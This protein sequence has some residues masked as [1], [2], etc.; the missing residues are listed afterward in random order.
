MFGS[1]SRTTTFKSIIYEVVLSRAILY[2]CSIKPLLL[3]KKSHF[4]T[5]GRVMSLPGRPAACTTLKLFKN[6]PFQ[7]WINYWQVLHAVNN[8][9]KYYYK[10]GRPWKIDIW[11]YEANKLL[12]IV[13][14]KL[15]Q[16]MYMFYWSNSYSQSRYAIV[17]LE[18]K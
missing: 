18:T 9:Y 13:K 14:E 7:L 3:K 10:R 15:N 2:S 17:S 5:A 8:P 11:I 1:R 6:S 4:M 16:N 12:S